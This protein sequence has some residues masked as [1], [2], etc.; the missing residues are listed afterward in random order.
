MK[1]LILSCNTGQGHNTAGRALLEAFTL[2][3]IEAQI[4]DT[5]TFG[6][7]RTSDVVSGSYVKITQRN[8]HMFGRLYRAGELISSPRLRSPVYYAN[9]LYAGKLLRFITDNGF[10]VVLCPHLFPAEALSWLR[11]RSDSPL[12]N[13]RIYGVATDYTCTPFWEETAVDRFFIPHAALRSE[14]EKK[15]FAPDLLMETGIPVS[16]A[17]RKKTDKAE[18]RRLLGMEMDMTTF[19]VMSGSMGF[20]DVPDITA[21]LLK[22]GG[23]KV[24]IKVLAG[25]NNDLKTALHARFAG[26]AR[27]SAIDYTTQV[28]LYMDACDVLLTKP[29]GLSS[30]EAAVKNVPTVHTSP[31]PGCETVNARFFGVFGMAMPTVTP[32]ESAEAALLLASDK[33][34]RERQLA[35]QREQINPNAADDILDALLILSQEQPLCV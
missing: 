8:P 5:L 32:R 19:L 27:V 1:A 10:D 22:L 26:D 9:A 16:R 24:R 18:A 13:V 23:S 31:I 25:H 12:Q 11:R 2:R 14:Y 7:P 29:G 28:S 30:T 15:G 35:S 17:F 4:C 34:L 33:D 21:E 3:G 6:G 20:G